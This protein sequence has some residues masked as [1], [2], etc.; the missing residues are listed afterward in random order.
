MIINSLGTI[1]RKREREISV[2]FSNIQRKRPNPKDLV[3]LISIT[4]SFIHLFVDGYLT[5]EID[6]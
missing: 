3:E 4:H 2:F 5:R 6:K 1:K